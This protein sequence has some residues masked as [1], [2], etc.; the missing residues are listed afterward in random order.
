M[1]H[2]VC[3]LIIL[4]LPPVAFSKVPRN[5]T[6]PVVFPEKPVDDGITE[7]DVEKLIPLDLNPDLDA[8]VPARIADRGVQLWFDSPLIQSSLL[9][10]TANTVQKKLKTDVVLAPADP[11]GIEHKF[12]F[13]LL[14]AQTMARL[15]YAGWLNAAFNYDAKAA[16]SMLEFSDKVF[17]KDMFLNVKKSSSENVGS[18]GIKWDW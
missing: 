7:R 11:A 5:S 8:T 13:Q 4:C 17:N 15:Q 14:A 3:L 12:S 18:V 6:K 9:G 16:S 1:K 2:L 10:R